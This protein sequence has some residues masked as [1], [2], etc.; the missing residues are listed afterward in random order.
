MLSFRYPWD[1]VTQ[2]NWVKYPN[3]ITPHVIHIDYL[4]RRIDPSTGILHTARLLTCRQPMPSWLMNL[5]GMQDNSSLILER[6]TVDPEGRRLEMRSCNLT[7]QQLIQME[8]TCVY[9]PNDDHTILRQSAEIKSLDC[10]HVIKGRV[11][12]FCAHRFAANAQ[13]GRAALEQVLE[14]LN[15]RITL[16]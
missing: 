4:Y 8:E 11:V 7:L 2:A 16:E 3:E 9:E 5:F 12:D 14:T 10:W 1:V 13:R 6:S 15:H